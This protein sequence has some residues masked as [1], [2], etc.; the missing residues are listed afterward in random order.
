[1]N[2]SLSGVIYLLFPRLTENKLEEVCGWSLINVD[3][4]C[5]ERFS[6]KDSFKEKI[7]I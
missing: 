2:L 5:R 1:M 4:F 7:R 3:K 6:G